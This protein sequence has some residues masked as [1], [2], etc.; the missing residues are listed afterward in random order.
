MFL[1]CLSPPHSVNTE[2]FFPSAYF[3]RKV[4]T[5]QLSK[6]EF[7]QSAGWCRKK[8]AAEDSRQREDNYPREVRHDGNLQNEIKTRGKKK[9]PRGKRD[10]G[11]STYQ[12]NG[13][14]AAA[15]GLRATGDRAVQNGELHFLHAPA[16]SRTGSASA[17]KTK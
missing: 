9:T 5:D 8:S 17:S 15:G 10:V 3:H 12:E 7:I 2:V 14:S 13:D 4:R 1:F 11:V 6:R 16:A